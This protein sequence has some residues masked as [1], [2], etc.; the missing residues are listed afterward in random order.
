MK[1]KKR[2]GRKNGGNWKIGNIKGE[3]KQMILEKR[4]EGKKV[5]K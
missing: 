1:I 5:G 4:R 2:N 3:V